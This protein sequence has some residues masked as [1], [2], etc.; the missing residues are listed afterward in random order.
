MVIAM[1]KWSV[2]TGGRLLDCGDALGADRNVLNRILAR[3]LGK[4]E[5]RASDCYAI[6][7]GGCAASCYGDEFVRV[8]ASPDNQDFEARTNEVVIDIRSLSEEAKETAKQILDR[9]LELGREGVQTSDERMAQAISEEVKRRGLTAKVHDWPSGWGSREELRNRLLRSG[10]VD[11]EQT[12]RVLGVARTSGQPGDAIIVD[13]PYEADPDADRHREK[14]AWRR[15]GIQHGLNCSGLAAPSVVS[16]RLDDATSMIRCPECRTY[17][18]VSDQWL[19]MNPH[20]MSNGVK[21]Q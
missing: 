11:E 9:M 2:R 16:S 7:A 14:R 5:V 21:L 15:G 19:A 13:I 1:T 4:F 3:E 20:V 10:G 12:N 18:I 6:I 8:L 17:A